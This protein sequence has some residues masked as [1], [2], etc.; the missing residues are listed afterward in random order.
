MPR[1]RFTVS[2][3]KS[4]ASESK[5]YPRLIVVLNDRAL[6]AL[7]NPGRVGLSV[8]HEPRGFFIYPDE[9]E[10]KRLLAH[11]LARRRVVWSW[12][13][14]MDGLGIRSGEYLPAKVAE[15]DRGRSGLFVEVGAR[16]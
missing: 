5:R 14:V 1:V 6:D 7:G 15:D 11:G 12:S 13:D 9:D 2:R 16:E 3:F 8:S 10:G 4:P